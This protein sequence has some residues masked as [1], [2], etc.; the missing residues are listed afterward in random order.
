[1]LVDNVCELFLPVSVYLVAVLTILCVRAF[2]HR[3]GWSKWA[4]LV[5][6]GWSYLFS[7]PAIANA[8]I[9]RIEDQYPAVTQ[10]SAEKDALIVVL[11]SGFVVKREGRVEPRLDTA[12]WERTYAGIRLWK[13]IGGRLLFVG[14]PT[15]DGRSSDASLMAELAI[16]AGVPASAVRVETKS[17]NTYQNLLFVHELAGGHGGNVWLVTSAIH[18][19][20]AMA[21]ARKL[22]LGMRPYPCDYRS[23][24]L[25]HWYAW[26]PN[27]GGPAMFADAMH[28]LVGIVYYRLKGYAS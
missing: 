4:L 20:R 9:G 15:P 6:L 16:G 10:V 21:V 23:V 17:R 28:E 7:T 14:G 22:D 24:S 5:L 27:S 19:P 8:I 1:M 3:R 18:M 13:Q 12:G 2:R 25:E 26:L 11:S